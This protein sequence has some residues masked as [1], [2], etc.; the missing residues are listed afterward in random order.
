MK[1]YDVRIVAHEDGT[2]SIASA[3]S[4][5]KGVHVGNAV[6]ARVL[7]KHYENELNEE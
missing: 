3:F 4:R 6:I 1:E 7:R 2:F 5:D